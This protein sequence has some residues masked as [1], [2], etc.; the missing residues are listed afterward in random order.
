MDRLILERWT[1]VVGLLDA[2]RKTQ[3]RIQEMI[4]VVGERLTRWAQPLGYE[5]E[6]NAK[7]AEFY[8][9]RSAWADR[10][11][12][13]RVQLVLGGFCPYGYRKNEEPYPY[14][15]VYTDPLENFRVKE[16]ERA[17]FA[18]SLRQALGDAAKQ[19]EADGIDDASQPLGKHLTD[20]SDAE[21][22]KLVSSPDALFDFAVAHYPTVFALAD[23]IEIELAKLAR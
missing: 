5:T 8:A 18:R 11:R 2:Q 3:D 1:D 10:R 14:L 19:W 15:W 23:T 22:P 6:A 16:T 20:V 4:D 13:P 21:R 7:E 9:W 17:A 12:G